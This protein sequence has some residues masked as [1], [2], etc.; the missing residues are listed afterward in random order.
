MCREQKRAMSG[1]VRVGGDEVEQEKKH[2]HNMYVVFMD[3]WWRS[4][5]NKQTASL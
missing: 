4:S 2:R 1:Q 5:R 3:G